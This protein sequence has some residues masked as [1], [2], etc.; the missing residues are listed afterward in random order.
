MQCCHAIVLDTTGTT[1]ARQQPRC[2]ER[3]K[4]RI[5]REDRKG[6]EKNNPSL[7]QDGYATRSCPARDATGNTKQTK[8]ES[9]TKH[10]LATHQ[11]K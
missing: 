8:T 9:T 2:V 4:T 5:A 7:E 3:E 11:D 6:G 1:H 10:R